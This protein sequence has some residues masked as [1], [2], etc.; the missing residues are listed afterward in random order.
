MLS[1]SFLVDFSLTT[2]HLHLLISAIL[3]VKYST[4]ERQFL[5]YGLHGNFGVPQLVTPFQL[6]HFRM[7]TDQVNA[8]SAD[9]DAALQPQESGHGQPDSVSQPASGEALAQVSGVSVKLPPF[10]SDDPQLWFAQVEAQF[11]TRNI[12][13]EST[14]FWHVVGSL[15]H[16]YAHEIRDLLLSPPTH[17]PYTE[18]RKTLVAR[19]TASAQKRVRQLLHAEQLGDRKPSQFL[20]HLR[21]LKGE[22]TIDDSILSE[23]FLQ[24]LPAG[25]RMVLATAS[26]LSLDKQAELADNILD[27]SSSTPGPSISAVDS[28]LTPTPPAVVAEI[29]AL[30]DELAALRSDMSSTAIQH[31]SRRSRDRSNS[32]SRSASRGKSSER[33]GRCYFHRRFGS[34]ARNCRPPCTEQSGNA[35]ASQ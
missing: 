11:N 23:L 3:N 1:S 19:L 14:K 31:P 34:A 10:W 25:V 30:R 18:L 16:K 15:D 35:T 5:S 13:V 21:Q 20:R 8:P 28:Q 4:L 29:E 33:D 9:A 26:T 32:R 2:C 6:E 7:L 17:Q 22:S 27:I 12:T 24:R